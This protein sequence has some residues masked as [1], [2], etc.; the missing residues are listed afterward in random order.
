MSSAPTVSARLPGASYHW[1][2]WG[3]CTGWGR[4]SRPLGRTAAGAGKERRESGSR[5]RVSRAPSTTGSCLS[6]RLALEVLTKD[7]TRSGVTIS[8]RRPPVSHTRPCRRTRGSGCTFW[9]VGRGSLVLF[10]WQKELF[11][12][13]WVVGFIATPIPDDFILTLRST[14]ALGASAFQT[15]CS[16]LLGGSE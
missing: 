9:S 12:E 15:F 16:V 8:A 2:V 6:S 11:K 10:G 3:E 4:R 1:E 5:L 14:V 7:G 13:R